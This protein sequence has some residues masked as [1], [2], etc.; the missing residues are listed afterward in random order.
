[1]EHGGGSIGAFLTRLSPSGQAFWVGGGVMSWMCVVWK[2]LPLGVKE[3][4]VGDAGMMIAC[5]APAEHFISFHLRSNAQNSNL[6][7]RV[8]PVYMPI[9]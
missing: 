5:Y 9:L 2:Q 7:Y 4:L 3:D 8:K 6:Y 1:M